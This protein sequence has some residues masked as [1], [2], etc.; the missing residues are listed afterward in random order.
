[1]PFVPLGAHRAQLSFLTATSGSLRTNTL[2]LHIIVPVAYDLPPALHL[3]PLTSA[4]PSPLVLSPRT[5]TACTPTTFTLASDLR[6]NAGKEREPLTV[7]QREV[8]MEDAH[9]HGSP[10]FCIRTRGRHAH[11]S[12]ARRSLPPPRRLLYPL[13]DVLA[14]G[15]SSS[16]ELLYRVL[17]ASHFSRH[18]ASA[19]EAGKSSST[20][21]RVVDATGT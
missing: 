4:A 15:A 14:L 21:A 18:L 19:R 20:L 2:P 8:E 17:R 10:E 3:S 5:S 6:T 11:L 9:R 1:M 7:R 16:I 13:L 12:P